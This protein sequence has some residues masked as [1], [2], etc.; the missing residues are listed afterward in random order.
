MKKPNQIGVFLL[1]DIDIHEILPF[2]DWHF[3][4]VA[5]RLPGR[6]DGV[7]DAYNGT[8]DKEEWIN[9]FEEKNREKAREALILFSESQEM[10]QEAIEK[11]WLQF[12]ATYSILPARSEGDDILVE[13][14]DGELRLPMLRQQKAASDGFCYSLAD[15][16]PEKDGYIGVFANTVTGAEVI[17]NQYEKEEDVYNA[18]LIKTLADRLAEG[19]A[20][21]LHWKIRKEFW[22]YAP[23]EDLSF[24]ELHKSK[25]VGIRP[26]VGYPSLPDQSL[27]FDLRP[28]LKFD[29]AHMQLTENGAMYPNASVSGIYFSHPESK[30]F[31]I[32]KIDEEQVQ[33]YAQRKGRPADEIRKW[34]AANL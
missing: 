26:A 20:E 8:I 17:S 29:E 21:W 27:I 33:D 34:L 10:L 6:Y 2:V 5:W 31:M 28:I 11:N 13:T 18:I 24:D 12:H 22:G 14:D 32:G 16:L 19:T 4:F 25:Y 1:N 30:Y 23:D 9:R 7:M 15:F 3:Y